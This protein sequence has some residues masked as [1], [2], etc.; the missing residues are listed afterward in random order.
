MNGIEL[1]HHYFEVDNPW[2]PWKFVK[3]YGREMKWQ[4]VSSLKLGRMKECYHNA[5]HL[6]AKEGYA[7]CE[8]Q[9]IGYA[10]F[11]QHHAWCLDPKSGYVIDPTWPQSYEGEVPYYYG[12]AL[13]VQFVKKMRDR[14][15]YCMLDHGNGRCPLN[16]HPIAE[17]KY[18]GPLAVAHP[19]RSTFD[20]FRRFSCPGSCP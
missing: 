1:I 19:A 17:W 8:G 5:Y 4:P 9:A 14:E 13:S 18:N 10:N 6:A 2:G 12:V 15:Q 20:A 7:Y 11:P 16:E 3:K